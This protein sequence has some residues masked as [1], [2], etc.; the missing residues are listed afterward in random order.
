MRLTTNYL[1]FS[2][3]I[4]KTLKI[5]PKG[6]PFLYPF[7]KAPQLDTAI[8]NRARSLGTRESDRAGPQV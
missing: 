4:G 7:L 5:S 8:R 6:V 1:N 3:Y 2:K